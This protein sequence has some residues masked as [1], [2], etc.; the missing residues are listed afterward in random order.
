MLMKWV[1]NTLDPM[2]AQ[3]RRKL[4]A[5]PEHEQ[6][7]D[8]PRVRERREDVT[9]PR[10]RVALCER[11]DDPA[12]D[13][14]QRNHEDAADRGVP[15]AAEDREAEKSTEASLGMGP[16]EYRQHRGVPRQL[17]VW[18]LVRATEVEHEDEER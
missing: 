12:S 4:G 14:A 9:H 16:Y 15:S 11:S 7:A 8:R 3:P 18:V 1:K 5:A 6:H 13:R 2:S 17:D 10:D